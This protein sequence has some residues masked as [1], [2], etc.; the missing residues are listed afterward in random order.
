MAIL[1]FYDRSAVETKKS[2]CIIFDPVWC[3]VGHMTIKKN[4]LLR[5]K[6]CQVAIYDTTSTS[7]KFQCSTSKTH[8]KKGM[9]W[10]YP[11]G[12]KKSYLV[13]D[14]KCGDWNHQKKLQWPTVHLYELIYH[15][16]YIYYTLG[17]HESIKKY[18]TQGAFLFLM[19]ISCW[20]I[21]LVRVL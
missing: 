1:R 17:L 18:G 11:Q 19:Q 4:C 16:T 12:F 2:S 13:Y 5:F 14:K 21:W 15:E 9:Q 10:L 3:T 6:K 8:C 7:Q 20:G